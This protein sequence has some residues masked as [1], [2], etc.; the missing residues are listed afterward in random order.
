MLFLQLSYRGYSRSLLFGWIYYYLH[1]WFYLST[2]VEFYISLPTWI[3][4]HSPAMVLTRSKK[5]HDTPH[6]HTGY[7][8]EVGSD[9]HASDA[10]IFFMPLSLLLYWR[11]FFVFQ[12]SWHDHIWRRRRVFFFS[13]C[14]IILVHSVL[15]SSAADGSE[16]GEYIFC[17][18]FYG[19]RISNNIFVIRNS[20][21]SPT[22][23]I[24]GVIDKHSKRFVIKLSLGWIS[25]L[26]SVICD[27]VGLNEPGVSLMSDLITH[28]L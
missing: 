17:F 18:V 2:A 12:K 23:G 16:P 11:N 6:P 15:L 27:L 20:V 26:W 19:M 25:D 22:K 10:L 14:L 21:K 4:C 28:L 3:L 24:E 8:S 7:T 5:R 1:G 13:F 9:M